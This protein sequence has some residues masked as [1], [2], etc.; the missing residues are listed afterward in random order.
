MSINWELYKE[1]KDELSKAVSLIF[2]LIGTA[3]GN[4][5]KEERQRLNA[6]IKDS[7]AYIH[8]GG[9]HFD[10]DLGDARDL[11]SGNFD[12]AI[13]NAQSV[14]SPFKGDKEITA[15]FI[16]LAQNFIVADDE[17]H[18]REEVAMK[19]LCEMLGVSE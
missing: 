2:Y 3:D 13:L 5:S 10:L 18:E 16:S 7:E 17:L 19:L 14:L 8:L 4:V 1:R 15:F 12:T 9:E 11:F 6:L